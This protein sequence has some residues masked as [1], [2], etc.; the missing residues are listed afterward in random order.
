ML[1]VY[2]FQHCFC[3]SFVALS[4]SCVINDEG[5]SS[6]VCSAIKPESHPFHS[7]VAPVRAQLKKDLGMAVLN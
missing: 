6:K 2:I 7:S 1:G 5:G 4:K 3:C